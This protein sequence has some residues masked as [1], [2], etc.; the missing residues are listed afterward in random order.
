MNRLQSWSIVVCLAVLF[1]ACGDADYTPKPR[2]FPKVVFP[3]HE[4]KA[5]DADYCSF[6]F[7]QPTYVEIEK[8]TTFFE[9]A[10]KDPCWFD[11]VYPK[12]NT[13][14]H[15]TYQPITK[16]KTLNDL[17]TESYAMVEEHVVKAEYI[18]E[19]AIQKKDEQVYGRTFDLEGPVATHFQ[20]YLTDSSRHFLRGALYTYARPNPDSLRPVVQFVKQ[21]IMEMINTIE[22]R[23][24]V[25]LIR[26]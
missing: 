3:Q 2:L 1:A 22:W 9:A 14:I 7:Q 24:S 18:D 19:Q 13:R 5:F 8:D 26:R 11:I 21:D 25:N 17:V 20:F 6:S 15:C 16:T 12:L 23:K 4:Y 10:P